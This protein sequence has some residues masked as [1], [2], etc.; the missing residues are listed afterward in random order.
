MGRS[1][2]SS[3]ADEM[4]PSTFSSVGWPDWPCLIEKARSRLT[5]A[6]IVLPPDVAA[7]VERREAEYLPSYTGASGLQDRKPRSVCFAPRESGIFRDRCEDARCLTW[8]ALAVSLCRE[9]PM[10]IEDP[11]APPT[12]E[13]TSTDH[14]WEDLALARRLTRL[15]ASFV[16]GIVGMVVA[17]PLWY[18][19]GTWDY[20]KRGQSPPPGHLIALTVLGFAGFVV[21]HGYFLMTNGQTIG[22]KLTAIRISDLDGRV[23]SFTTL[24][25]FRYLPTN[26]V[27]LVPYIGP[28]LALA[29]I[30]FIFGEDAPVHPRPDRRHKGNHREVASLARDP[31]GRSCARPQGRGGPTSLRML[32][33]VHG[34]S[35]QTIG[36]LPV[37]YSDEA[38]SAL[39]ACYSYC[40][41][42]LV[43]G[44]R[45]RTRGR[46]PRA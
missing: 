39:T 3:V 10:S 4:E 14:I 9:P 38:S 24:I 34:S 41:C 37:S 5:G 22:K 30:V 6:G 23:P 45:G 12:S 27:A 46:L 20:F 11:Y 36:A 18:L 2:L 42:T 33:E 29:D 31:C 32:L 1:T 16:D 35:P 28:Y 13:L 43:T 25:L 26:L 17:V 7:E 21:L 44:R 40:S 19:L 15:A 8:I